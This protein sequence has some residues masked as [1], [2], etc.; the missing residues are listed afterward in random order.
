MA[1][2]APLFVNVSPGGMQWSSDLIG[3]DAMN[4][5]GS[6]SY[7]TQVMFSSCL[8]DQ[9]MESKVSGGGGQ[10]F[11]SVTASKGSRVC[12]KLV[13]AASAGDWNKGCRRIRFR[14]WQIDLK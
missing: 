6:P 3:D 11:Y 14:S 5:Y 8:G 12:L 2:C 1:A 9:T 7:S 4:S 10:F 13:D